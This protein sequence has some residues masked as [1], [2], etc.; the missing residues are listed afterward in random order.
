MVS[1][2]SKCP[3]ETAADMI[4]QSFHPFVPYLE[5]SIY[6]SLKSCSLNTIDLLDELARHPRHPGERAP[7]P[8]GRPP[9]GSSGPHVSTFPLPTLL[10]LS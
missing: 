4:A 5:V 1:P 9:Y 3:I 2:Q 8:G 10:T 7:T 6:L